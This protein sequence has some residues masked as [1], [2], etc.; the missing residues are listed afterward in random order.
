MEQILEYFGAIAGLVYIVLEIK[1]HRAMWIVGLLSS[2]VYVFVFFSAK[3][4]AGMGL[5]VYYVS[6]SIYGFVQ[7]SQKEKVNH[8]DKSATSDSKIIYRRLNRSMTCW[9]ALTSVIL[10]GGIYYVLQQTDSPVVVGDSFTSALSIVGTWMLARRIIEHWFCW[11]VV[12]AISV[13]LY[14]TQGLYPTLVLYSCF[15][16][17]A[18]VGLYIWI[19]NGVRTDDRS[20]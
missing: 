4:Y 16:I 11:I 14:S 19:K 1:Q 13:Y 15:T 9:L 8:T 6:M 17:M 10:F 5:H 20:L 3:F 2:I 12:N 18:G 7:W